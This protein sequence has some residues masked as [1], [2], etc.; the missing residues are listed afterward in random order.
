MPK[1]P[2]RFL[3]V[4]KQADYIEEGGPIKLPLEKPF[5]VEGKQEK[6]RAWLAKGL[7]IIFGST[8]SAFFLF[9][10]IGIVFP[11]SVN[12]E[13]LKELLILILTSEV[14]IIGTAL[15]FYFGSQTKS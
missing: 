9:I 7:V 15:G 11:T 3:D 2:D 1:D 13:E 5:N 6:T 10:L 14:G 8:I 4:A 12:T